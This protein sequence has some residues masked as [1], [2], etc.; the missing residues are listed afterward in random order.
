MSLVE[1][2]VQVAVDFTNAEGSMAK[3]MAS[4]TA[5]FVADEADD[6]DVGRTGARDHSHQ[7]GLPDARAAVNGD[8]GAG[9]R[10]GVQ[11]QV[12]QVQE[13]VPGLAEGLGR[14]GHRLSSSSRMYGGSLRP[15]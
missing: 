7:R 8:D 2:G 12:A 13:Q 5:M 6:D 15:T 3:L 14:S 1:N 9:V 11:T 10:R 4:E